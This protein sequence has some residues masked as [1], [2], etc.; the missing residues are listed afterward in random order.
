MKIWWN[1]I[2]DPKRE[3]RDF[4]SKRL[5][6]IGSAQRNDIVLDSGYV[7]PESAILRR[8]D[9]GWQLQAKGQNI[10]RVEQD[11][12]S[13]GKSL[14]I[15]SN[16]EIKIYPFTLS[17]EFPRIVATTAELRRRALDEKMSEFIAE[18]HVDIVRR[19]GVE[20]TQRRDVQ[21]EEAKLLKLE[22]DIEA[23][24]VDRGL[25]SGRL[26]DLVAHMAGSCLRAQ[27]LSMLAAAAKSVLGGEGL[28]PKEGWSRMHS[29]VPD[30]E[31]EL[32]GTCRYFCKVMKVDEEQDVSEKIRIADGEFW[33]CWEKFAKGS[34]DEVHE[35][36]A[37]RYLK[38][39]VKD[40]LFGYGPLEDLI[41]LPTITEIMVVDSERIYVENGGTLE[42]SGRRFISDEVTLNIIQRIV[43]SVGRTIDKSRPMVDARLKSGDRVNA[44]IPPLA[45]SGPCL[46]IRKFPQR[47]VALEELVDTP[48]RKKSLSQVAAD[49]L[50]ASV[51]N[52][53]NILISGGTGTGKTT[54]LNCLSECIPDR[55]RI[56]TV[57]DTAELKLQKRH[58]IS[59][60]T[61]NPNADGAGEVTIQDLVKNAL[62]M[63]PDRIVVGECRGAEALDML[64]AMNTGHD[65]SLTTI[66][67]NT[68]EDV[69]LRLEVLVQR[70]KDTDLPIDSIHRMI[71]SAI[72]LIVQLHR[73]RNGRRIVSQISEI[74]GIDPVTKRVKIRDLFLVNDEESAEAM[75]TPT[76]HLPSFI[77]EL[78]NR[79]LLDL[80][81][82]TEVA[83]DE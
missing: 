30:R 69:V 62:R 48:E 18:I 31:E 33:Q 52:R 72:D 2:I 22:R 73:M 11:E 49:F 41:A 82:F 50:R 42:D 19:I 4:T 70:S 23:F 77:G 5:I 15:E 66:H 32:T 83:F 21:I 59:L 53:R 16:Q 57:E 63:R 74:V 81:S 64:Q 54:M 29:E 28:L 27:I 14:L 43:Q 36:P 76:G 20:R 9:D 80:N 13:D 60:E 12:L 40:I 1:N 71:A 8:R 67:A 79:N 56:V 55:E 46:T 26:R 47:S 45:V 78:I 34:I 7:E 17:L 6:R 65:G 35:Y 68:A 61:K 75:L 51:V 3:F 39:Q 38:K 10:I 58:V 24:A 44:V 25:F 37:M